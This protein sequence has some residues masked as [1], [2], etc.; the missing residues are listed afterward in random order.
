MT[1]RVYNHRATCLQQ[2]PLC[3]LCSKAACLL[4]YVLRH[5]LS[6]IKAIVSASALWR[7]CS[8][9]PG[10]HYLACT[11]RQ[12]YVLLLPMLCGWLQHH[13]IFVERLGKLDGKRM[14]KQGASDDLALSYHLRE[15]EFMAQVTGV[16]RQPVG[17]IPSLL[18]VPAMFSLCSGIKNTQP[19]SQQV[20]FTC[21]TTS[22][23]Q[24]APMCCILQIWGAE[25]ELH[26][27]CALS[28]GRVCRGCGC[29]WSY[30]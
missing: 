18:L 4:T 22:S 7:A 29:C 17:I 25:R 2:Q 16:C 27:L 3:S 19:T 12:Q 1:E 28:A 26:W 30:C 10:Q 5:Q 8:S 24:I 20:A 21:Q 11:C 13:P 15:M 9:C 23:L 14:E 6:F